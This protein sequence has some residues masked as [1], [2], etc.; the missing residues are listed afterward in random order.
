M[1]S[2]SGVGRRRIR[3]Q[4]CRTFS[5]RRCRSSGSASSLARSSIMRPST[6]APRSVPTSSDLGGRGE[7]AH[8]TPAEPRGCGNRQDPYPANAAT[9]RTLR[10]SRN[11]TSTFSVLSEALR[12]AS[13][14][15]GEHAAEPLTCLRGVLLGPAAVRLDSDTRGVDDDRHA[16]DDHGRAGLR[17]TP[18][19]PRLRR[20][21]RSEASHRRLFA[22]QPLRWSPTSVSR[23][24]EPVST[25]YVAP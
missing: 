6:S 21:Q 12:I 14:G 8:T 3:S 15:R 24:A 18:A 25:I 10:T 11:S 2:W 17:A 22:R 13:A 1:I 4:T 19:S 9:A 20:Y 23:V 16:A 7:S 5:S